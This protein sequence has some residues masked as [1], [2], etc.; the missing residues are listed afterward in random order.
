MV[1]GFFYGGAEIKNIYTEKNIDTKT[2][3]LITEY[4]LVFHFRKID[5]KALN[6]M[7]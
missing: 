7:I 1:F 5:T 3:S 2:N 6:K 4:H